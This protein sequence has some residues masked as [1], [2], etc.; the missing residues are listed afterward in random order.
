MKIQYKNKKFAVGIIILGFFVLFISGVI[1]VHGALKVNTNESS[2]KA[3]EHLKETQEK[4]S[5][6]FERISEEL[7]INGADDDSE[8]LGISGGLEA[9]ADTV[10]QMREQITNVNKI[11]ENVHS[12]VDQTVQLITQLRDAQTQNKPSASD[13]AK[14]LN[15]LQNVRK[16]LARDTQKEAKPFIKAIVNIIDDTVSLS[17]SFSGKKLK[18]AHFIARIN[19]NIDQ[20]LKIDNDVADYAVSVDDVVR[21]SIDEVEDFLR[22]FDE[23]FSSYD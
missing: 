14:I 13:I 12:S 15:G 8:G 11:V 21:K 1:S 20:I 7:A 17:R 23:D 10:N 22:D 19:K 6:V 16:K 18:A 2:L 5:K 9:E 3:M 4:L